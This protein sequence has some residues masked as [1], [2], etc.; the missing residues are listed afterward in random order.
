MPLGSPRFWSRV[1][2]IVEKEGKTLVE[3][4]PWEQ[5]VNPFNNTTTTKRVRKINLDITAGQEG[6]TTDKASV[7]PFA[8]TAQQNPVLP[9]QFA[10]CNPEKDFPI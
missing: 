4:Q 8:P 7:I 1:R 3:S 2:S 10:H 6:A 9:T 5:V